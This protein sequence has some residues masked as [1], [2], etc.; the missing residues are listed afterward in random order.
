[1]SKNIRN[2]IVILLSLNYI[3]LGVVGHIG[4]LIALGF[5]T[6]PHCITQAKTV[7][8]TTK[9]YWTQ[10]K[11]IPATIKISIPSP[12]VFASPE[13]RRI[14]EYGVLPILDDIRIYPDPVSVLY[15]SRAP[16]QI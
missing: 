15:S 2:T 14:Q 16:P 8:S 11:H 1:M 12:A 7:P 13:S 9:V 6:N 3:I 5:G 10:Y 4:I